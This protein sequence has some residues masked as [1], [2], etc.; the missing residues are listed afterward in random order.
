MKKVSMY[1]LST[2][3]LVQEDEE[4]LH[5]H[6]IPYEFTDFDL[7]DPA[8]QDRIMRE[9]EPRGSTASIRSDRRSGRRRLA[10]AR[11]AELLGHPR[12][13]PMNPEARK[14][15]A[16]PLLRQG[17][18]AAGFPSSRRTPSWPSFSSTRK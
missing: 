10:A 12:R 17:R 7:A 5:E 6:H 4:V 13:R 15:G 2:C 1:T 11:Y 16:A 9:L 3:P 18:Q 14:K 8:T